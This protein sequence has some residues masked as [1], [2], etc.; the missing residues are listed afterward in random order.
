MYFDIMYTV[1][2]AK[3]NSSIMDFTAYEISATDDLDKPVKAFYWK[4]GTN[5]AND[6]DALADAEWSFK[7]SIK[8]DASMGID[9]NDGLCFGNI[10]S[11]FNFALLI[12]RIYEYAKSELKVYESEQFSMMDYEW[13]D[14][15]PGK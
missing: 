1:V 13:G 10:T 3:R 5:L 12:R 6:T 9:F 11:A 15:W 8:Y 4:A 7:G 2:F 14:S